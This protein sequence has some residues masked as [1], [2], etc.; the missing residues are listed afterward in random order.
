MGAEM[1]IAFGVFGGLLAFCAFV[2]NTAPGGTHNLG[3]LQNQMMLLHVGL[4]L[5]II[6]A[7][8]SLKNSGV[9]QG[10]APVVDSH[11]ETVVEA[12]PIEYEM[13]DRPGERAFVIK[14]IAVI[15]VIIIS[16][17]AIA[18]FNLLEGL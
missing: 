16:V 6:G 18:Y 14:L 1:G 17:F 4:A 5:M 12:V 2:I 15:A 3:L 7:I 10:T 9:G 11:S 13:I 8:L